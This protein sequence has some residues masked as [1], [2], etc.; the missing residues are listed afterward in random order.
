MR[1]RPLQWQPRP[2]LQPT[3]FQQVALLRNFSFIAAE[4]P[5]PLHSRTVPFSPQYRF[6]TNLKPLLLL[7]LLLLGCSRN[8]F[9]SYPANYREFA[10]VSNGG[11]G[12]VTVLDLV[13]LRQDRVLQ[14]GR[15]PS[16][17]SVNP[18]RNEV[19][20]VNAGSDSVSVIDAETNT[21]AATIGVH[22]TPYFMAVAPDG[23]RGY[24]PNTG[25]NTVSVLD[26]DKRREIAIEATG[27]G[28]GVAA[29]SPDN[30][31]LVV[32]NRA[33]GS[34]SV[35]TI[36]ATGKRPLQL[37][38]AFSGCPGATD[39]VIESTDPND[40]GSGGKAFVACSG[41]HQVMV[42]WLAAT[43]QSWRGS[44]EATLQHDHLLSLL[45]VGKTPTH[46]TLASIGVRRVYSTNFDSDSISE[47]NTWTNEV[48]GTT[49][50]GAKPSRAVISRD[51]SS[52]WVSNFGADSAGL[53]SPE[54]DRIETSV[55][56]GSRPDAL[57]FSADEHLLLVA[58]A[59]SADVAVIRTQS[60]DGPSLVTLLPAGGPAND[61]VVKSFRAK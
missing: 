53:Y 15:Q 16:G 44:Q 9:P 47:I 55:R 37:R 33:A 38:E 42:L 8:R 28:P 43:P 13:Y 1:T 50:V 58:D 40:P 14:V 41:G 56:T 39:I 32:S 27:E 31:T 23:K 20:A 59:G 52:L 45:D 46:L 35:Y 51:D 6:A 5:A 30:R 61:I 7:P 22:H 60:K 17:L 29:V 4:G 2:L 21:V 24:V 19:Y 12:T 18:L 25:S 57:A 49:V 54:D 34:V 48:L 11:A 26:L 36:S 10:Y 3:S